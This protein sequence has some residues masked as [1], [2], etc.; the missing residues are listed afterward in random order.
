MWEKVRESEKPSSKMKGEE[1]L[2]KEIKKLQ[3]Y[4][5]QIKTWAATA[6]IKNKQPLLDARANVERRMEA[7]K[8]IERETKTKAYSKEGLA[9]SDANM[10]PE[11][12]KRNRTREWLQDMASK[13]SDEIEEFEQ[14][15]EQLGEF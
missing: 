10:T 6:E 4:R 15:L 8:V 2:K 11:E 14:E 3:K 1:D 9:R 13:F 12:R 7:F 5:D